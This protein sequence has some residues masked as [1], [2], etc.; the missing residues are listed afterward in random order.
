MHKCIEKC[1]FHDGFA[2]MTGRECSDVN[3]CDKDPAVC[4][5][6]ATCTNLQGR[7]ICACTRECFFCPAETCEGGRS[8]CSGLLFSPDF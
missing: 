3:E 4:N 2:G 1:T 5:A 6:Q 8:T 7:H